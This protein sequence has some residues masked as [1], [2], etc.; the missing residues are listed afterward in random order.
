VNGSGQP[1][2]VREV[3]VHPVRRE[4]LHID[5]YAPNMFQPVETSVPVTTIGALGDEVEAELT[6]GLFEVTVRALPD[7]IPN[8]I[9]VDI[10]GLREIGDSI[11]VSDLVVP[12]GVTMMTNAD[13]LIAKLDPIRE[14]EIDEEPEAEL[15]EE[16]GEEGEVEGDEAAEPDDGSSEETDEDD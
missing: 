6:H 15:V 16:I 11:M 8:Q 3:Q 4:I 14:E 5:F 2:F 7:Q 9:E 13:D 12:E 10:S 1:V